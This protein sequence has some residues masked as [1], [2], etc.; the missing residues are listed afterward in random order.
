M[1]L[2]VPHAMPADAHNV[3]LDTLCRQQAVSF[4][5]LLVPPVMDLSAQAVI[6]D[7][8]WILIMIVKH[9]QPTVPP[10]M[11]AG[12]HNVM[13]DTLCRQQAVP[14]VRPHVPPVTD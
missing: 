1:K 11:P 2:T 8:T 10:A 7:I 4:V 3:I 14:L 13:P 6:L 5:R 9:V 12:A